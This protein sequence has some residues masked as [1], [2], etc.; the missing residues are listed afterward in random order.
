MWR[1]LYP[2]NPISP[3][4]DLKE[5]HPLP[6]KSSHP[7]KTFRKSHFSARW[8]LH[9]INYAKCGIWFLRSSC[10]II[11]GALLTFPLAP[12]IFI[13]TPRILLHTRT[14]T[15]EKAEGW[16]WGGERIRLDGASSVEF[17]YSWSRHIQSL[18]FLV[19]SFFPSTPFKAGVIFNCLFSA[20]VPCVM[21]R[22]SG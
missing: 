21:S 22:Q 13:K 15:S 14:K 2:Q 12:S 19:F 9:L 6:P 16:R 11:I 5:E 20:I 1:A 10:L 4:P 8:L 18:Y 7:Y 17:A 3:K